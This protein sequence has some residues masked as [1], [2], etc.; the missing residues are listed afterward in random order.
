MGG[1]SCP[2]NLPM[3]QISANP[4][5]IMSTCLGAIIVSVRNGYMVYE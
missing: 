2:Q 4:H 5:D 1:K 3:F